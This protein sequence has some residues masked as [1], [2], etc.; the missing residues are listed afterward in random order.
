MG[1]A[2]PGGPESPLAPLSPASPLA[3]GCPSA[4][5]GGM[6]K[7][8]HYFSMN[9]LLKLQDKHEELVRKSQT[10]KKK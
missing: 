2:A 3:P 1:P 8:T 9:S 10:F 5:C 7:E 4:P 6:E